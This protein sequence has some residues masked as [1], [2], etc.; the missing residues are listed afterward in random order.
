MHQ[1][2]LPGAV[3]GKQGCGKARRAGV[4][5]MKERTSNHAYTTREGKNNNKERYEG[6]GEEVERVGSPN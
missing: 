1:C 2:V 4:D 5:T 6:G 3:E